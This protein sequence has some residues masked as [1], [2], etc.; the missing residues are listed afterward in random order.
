LQSGECP[1]ILDVRNPDELTGE[2][3]QIPNVL[4][5]PVG[6]LT[7]KLGELESMKEKEIVTVCKGGGRAHT[8]AQILMQAGFT[9]VHVMMGGML[10]WKLGR[11]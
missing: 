9:D 2:L 6:D 1:I 10:A 4:N 11:E 7:H 8:A 3:G 5:I